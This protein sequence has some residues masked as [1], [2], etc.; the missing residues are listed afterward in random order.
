MGNS[1]DNGFCIKLSP[2]FCVDSVFKQW[3][4]IS[5]SEVTEILELKSFTV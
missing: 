1:T 2:L 3:G 4:M 5:L